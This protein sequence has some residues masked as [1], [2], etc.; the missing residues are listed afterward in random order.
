MSIDFSTLKGLTI[1]EGNVTQIT[2]ESGRVL[3]KAPPSAIIVNLI[4][5]DRRG[6][7]TIDG[8]KYVNAGTYE[9]LESITVGVQGYYGMVNSSPIVRPAFVYLN[10]VQVAVT[11]SSPPPQVQYALSLE[12]CTEVTIEYK[13]EDPTFTIYNCYITTK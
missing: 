5:P 2:D 12:G 1:P 7:V 3:W 4:C 6:N 8:T 10:N 9:A 11:P 13:D